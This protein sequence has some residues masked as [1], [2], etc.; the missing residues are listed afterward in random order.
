VW[1]DVITGRVRV[2]VCNYRVCFQVRITDRMC[3]E[4]RNHRQSVIA[5]MLLVKIRNQ[6]P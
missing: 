3:V 4:V 6:K 2:K 5:K 1:R